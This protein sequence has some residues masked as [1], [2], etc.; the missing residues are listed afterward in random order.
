MEIIIKDIP[1]YYEIHGSGAPILMIHGWSVDHRLMKG[2][3]EPLFESNQSDWQRLYFDLP[4]MG[5][6]PGRSWINGSDRMVE[7]ILELVDQLLPNQNFL[8]AGESYGGYLARAI[9]KKR[10]PQV[11]GLLL[12]CPVAYQGTRNLPDLKILE[13][14]QEFINSLSEEEQKYFTGISIVQNEKIWKSFKQDVL[15]ALKIADYNF[16]EYT[17]AQNTSFKED[18]DQ[19]EKPY[20]Q[21]ALFL[22]GRQDNLVG[23]R[24]QWSLIENFP[25]ASFVVLDKAGH[26]LQIEQDVLFQATVKEWLNR[27]QS[28]I[29]T[30]K[31]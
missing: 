18:V 2:C 24:D 28:E 1:I 26:N 20:Q 31:H 30:R 6:T 27:V 29:N 8:I 5:N 21:P 22:M 7:I 19:I 3:M 13:V 14:D 23:Y 4:G 9:L 11:N 15:P 10:E 16:L 12:I 17:L 25:R